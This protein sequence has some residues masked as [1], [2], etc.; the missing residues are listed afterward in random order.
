MPGPEAVLGAPAFT[1]L[2]VIDFTVANLRVTIVL[3]EVC[4]D[5]GCVKRWV[6]RLY[7]WVELRSAVMVACAEVL[8]V[9]LAR[10]HRCA[11]PAGRE[12]KRR[13]TRPVV[14]VPA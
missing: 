9:L 3:D 5:G 1:A 11:P 8:I 7:D 4:A 2:V 14:G 6:L 13:T 12:P 10:P